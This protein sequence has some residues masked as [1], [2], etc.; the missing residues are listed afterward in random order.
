MNAR[1]CI[2][3]VQSKLKHAYVSLS[4]ICSTRVISKDVV[5]SFTELCIRVLHIFDD[6]HQSWRFRFI[7]FLYILLHFQLWEAIPR[8]SDRGGRPGSGGREF[9]NMMRCSEWLRALQWP[10]GD[11][12]GTRGCSTDTLASSPVLCIGVP[13]NKIE[14]LRQTARTQPAQGFDVSRIFSE[15]ISVM[16]PY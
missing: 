6:L 5:V 15:D 10:G 7:F 3:T 8:K 4:H 16:I 12:P 9:L 13:K 11:H 14:L 2:S 1:A